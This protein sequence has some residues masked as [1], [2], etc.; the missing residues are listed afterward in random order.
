MD[1]LFW[2]CRLNN[3]VWLVSHS[4]KGGEHGRDICY[5]KTLIRKAKYGTNIRAE[6]DSIVEKSMK[7]S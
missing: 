4:E 6:K 7:N 2:S 3:V 5:L 1:K